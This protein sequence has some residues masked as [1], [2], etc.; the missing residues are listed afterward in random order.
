M[1]KP[2][3]ITILAALALM[4]GAVGTWTDVQQLHRIAPG[5]ARGLTMHHHYSALNGTAGIPWAQRPLCEWIVE[6]L[7]RVIKPP[8]IGGREGSGLTLLICILRV[9]TEAG[10]ILAAAWYLRVWRIGR[11]MTVLLCCTIG[12][13]YLTCCRDAALYLNLHAE[14]IM[15]LIA[16]GMLVRGKTTIPLILIPFMAANRETSIVIPVMMLALGWRHLGAIALW[17]AVWVGVNA[18]T[19]GCLRLT[20]SIGPLNY[21]VANIMREATWINHAATWMVMPALALVFWRKWPPL[22]KRWF[23]MVAPAWM[24]VN[25]IFCRVNETRV[26]LLPYILFVLPVVGQGVEEAAPYWRVEGW[27]GWEK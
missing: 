6:G 3:F 1:T 2:A 5:Y 26:F 24:I 12:W 18:H 13:A 19:L 8:D 16:A 17:L 21:P 7:Y 22:L 10:V 23:W 14:L 27:E 11:A 20:D 4:A 25:L 15:C 9:F